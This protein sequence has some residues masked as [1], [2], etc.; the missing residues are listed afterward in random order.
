MAA[1]K[2]TQQATIGSLGWLA[3]ESSLAQDYISQ[4]VE[5]FSYSV[6][7]E[8]DWLNEHMAGIFDGTQ[9]SVHLSQHV[10]VH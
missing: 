3:A 2:T 6:R 7:N 4:E 10:E 5:D 1:S 9:L 8:F